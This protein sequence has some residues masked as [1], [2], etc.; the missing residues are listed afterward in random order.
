M[1]TY[2]RLDDNGLL[3]FAQSFLGRIRDLIPTK[4]SQLTNDSN[5]IRD[6]NY[7][8]TDNN[9]TTTE[10]TKLNAAAPLVSPGF[11]GT[12]TAPTAASGTN[13]TQIATT[14]FVMSAISGITGI[15]FQVVSSLP[16]TG[17]TGTIYLVA[18]GSSTT[19]NIYDEYIWLAS[20]SSYEKIGTTQ[21]DLSGYVQASEMLSITNTEIDT[22]VT[23]A[24]SN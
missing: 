15:D 10:K 2:K 1:A 7:V 18:N 23:N 6:A 20:S 19:Q 14:E 9:Y 12:P 3:Y 24:F 5:F 21:V 22:I 16:A 4:T 11:S 8:H 13:T 17:T